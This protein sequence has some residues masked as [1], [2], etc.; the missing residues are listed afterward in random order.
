M[1]TRTASSDGRWIDEAAVAWHQ[2]EIPSPVAAADGASASVVHGGPGVDEI[3]HAG[4]QLLV[5]PREAA[6]RLA[7]GRT[8]VYDLIA[9]GELESVV[10]GRCRRVPVSSLH[11]FVS[12]LIGPNR[13]RFT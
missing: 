12:R 3:L 10:I 2:P 1:N 6:R 7:L 9:R 8:T 13:K 5:T 4:D 11:E